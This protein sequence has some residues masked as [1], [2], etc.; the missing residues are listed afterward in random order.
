M[1]TAE[2]LVP[3]LRSFEIEIV[4]EE[5]ERYISPDANQSVAEPVQAGCNT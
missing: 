2:L 1:H 4:V 5:T 3:E